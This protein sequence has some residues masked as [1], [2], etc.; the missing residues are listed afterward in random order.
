MRSF[1]IA[2]R[3]ASFHAPENTL[4]AFHAAAELGADGVETDVQLTG[5]GELVV[6]HNYAI[7]GC[8][9][10]SGMIAAMS[11][12]E[13]KT[14]D[15]GSYHGGEWIPEQILTLDE[16]L[17]AAKDFAL[18]DVEL[19]APLDSSAPFVRRVTNAVLAHG[20]RER[21]VISAFDHNLLREVKRCCKEMR[22]GVLTMPTDFTQNRLFSLLRSYLPAERKLI[23]VARED[24]RDMPD[25]TSLASS[26]GI[27]SADMTGA[28]VELARQIGA[29]YPRYTIREAARRWTP[30]VIWSAT[31]RRWI[32][33]PIFCIAI[34]R[35]YCANPLWWRRSRGWAW[36]AIRGRRTSRTTW[37]G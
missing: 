8:S 12:S 10:G 3:G 34:F 26:V 32:S 36:A 15:F 11:L 21:V 19:K 17:D 16:F 25:D 23:E 20:M 28:I 33:R 7:D 29:V 31:L 1:I 22:V 27:R 30:R 24:L 5:D 2:H 13:L 14:Y 6:H 4:S 18:T 37:R 35:P 9:N